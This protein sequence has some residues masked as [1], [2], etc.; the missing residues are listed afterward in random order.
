MPQSFNYWISGSY[1]GFPYYTHYKPTSVT[2]YEGELVADIWSGG[3]SGFPLAGDVEEVR[4]G[5]HLPGH[6]TITE[7]Q[8]WIAM[9]GYAASGVYTSYVDPAAGSALN[10]NVK[11]YNTAYPS[12]N[13]YTLVTDVGTFGPYG[14]VW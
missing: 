2:D 8:H 12:S 3:A 10:W 6:P 11:A 13:I 1:S 9:Y 5:L 14:I 4:N 7:I